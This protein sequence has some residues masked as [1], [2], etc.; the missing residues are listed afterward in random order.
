M[1]TGKASLPRRPEPTAR[2]QL[3]GTFD[4][5]PLTGRY[6]EATTR[7]CASGGVPGIF[8]AGVVVSRRATTPTKDGQPGG[9]A[10]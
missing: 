7:Q 2:S 4:A 3:A 1:S 9:L 6:N 10:L 8:V 5:V